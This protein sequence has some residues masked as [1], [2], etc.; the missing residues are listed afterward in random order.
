MNKILYNKDYAKGSLYG[1]GIFPYW[2]YVKYLGK[3][4]YKYCRRR[5]FS[6]YFSLNCAHVFGA[7]FHASFF[8]GA[9]SLN[10]QL[11]KFIISFFVFPPLFW[12]IHK[13]IWKYI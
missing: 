1:F 11:V 8:L 9:E 2:L 13:Y 6:K 5:K 4:I 10:S 7:A 12:F 3:P